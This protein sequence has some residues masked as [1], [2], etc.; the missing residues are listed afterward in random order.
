MRPFAALLL[1][2][3]LC[4]AATSRVVGNPAPP[5]RH[6]VVFFCPEKPDAAVRE[7][8]LIKRDGYDLIK[9]SSWVWTLPKPGSQLERTVQAVLDWCDRNDMSFFLMHNIQYGN[10]GEGAGL[11]DQVLHPERTLP[12]LT[13]WAH[14]LR[15]HPSVMGVILGN[16]V[17]FRLGTP[18]EAPDLWREFRGWLAARHGSIQS[19]NSAWRTSFAAF[20]DVGVPPKDSPGWLDCDRYARLRFAQFYGALFD[21]AFR[22]S[23][24]EKLYGNKTNPDPFLHRLCARMTMTCWDDLVALYP[25]WEIKCAADTTGKPLFNAEL[26]LYHDEY[27]YF[28]SPAASRYRYF[29][30]ALLGEYLTASFAWHQWDKPVIAR[31]HSHTPQIFADL[32]R[33]EPLC[34]AMAHAYQRAD[35]AVLLAE[36]NW[37]REDI[38]QTARWPQAILYAHMSALGKPWRYVLEDDLA[39][40]K[41]GVVV[42]WARR[43]RP[44]AA[45]AVVHLPSSVRVIA[46]GAVPQE[47]EYGRPLSAQLQAALGRR[48]EVIP[49]DGLARAIGPQPGLPPEYQRAGHVGYM[50]WDDKLGHYRFPVPYCLLEARPVQTAE[51]LLVAVINNTLLPQRAPIPWAR[52]REVIDAVSGRRVNGRP[53]DRRVFGPLGVRLFLLKPRR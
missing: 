17:N 34:R 53:T 39:A 9:F 3:L 26:H 33:V 15:G 1:G 30:S 46:V 32:R 37:S 18:Q 29:T 35:L 43:L 14:V 10:P 47:D 50:W 2:L 44:D 13:D 25:L 49:L 4:L 11:N 7:L 48:V 27:E 52:G 22:P 16:E 24:G 38:D 31:I 23:L 41:R 28:P 21:Q 45:Q 20:D 6:G 40:V 8:E 42:M 12:L 19:L 36:G 51:G 5:M